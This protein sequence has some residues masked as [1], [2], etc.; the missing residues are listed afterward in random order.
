MLLDSKSKYLIKWIGNDN[1]QL[2]ILKNF[3]DR[4]KIPLSVEQL[5]GFKLQTLTNQGVSTTYNWSELS[6]DI[7]LGNLEIGKKVTCKYCNSNKVDLFC[8]HTY[9][10]QECANGSIHHCCLCNPNK[11]LYLVDRD[12]NNIPY[13]KWNN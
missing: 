2:S 6:K 7:Q 13:L 10:C 1:Q 12:S 11:H 3:L 4:T 8:L 5:V 9:L